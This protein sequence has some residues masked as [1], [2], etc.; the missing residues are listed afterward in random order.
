MSAYSISVRTDPF[1][2]CYNF[3]FFPKGFQ[4]KYDKD[5]NTTKQSILFT[6]VQSV[7]LDYLYQDKIHNLTI[8]LKDNIRYNYC[9]KCQGDAEKVY[10]QLRDSL[11]L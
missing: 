2:Q 5:N 1:C 6:E 9:F 7:R 11:L 3:E 10:E 4:V 8:M